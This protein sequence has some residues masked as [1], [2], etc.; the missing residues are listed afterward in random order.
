MK[1]S[2]EKIRFA[3]IRHFTSFLRCSMY[4]ISNQSSMLTILRFRRF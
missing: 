2:E 1:L 3:G 4:S